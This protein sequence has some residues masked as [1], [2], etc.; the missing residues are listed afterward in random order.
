RV[1][2]V[3][4]NL[5]RTVTT[6]EKVLASLN[7]SALP[8]IKQRFP[9]VSFAVAG[10]AEES[11]EA[12]GA[13]ASLSLM[14]MLII[15]ALL[16][17]P[18]RSYLQP[19]VIMSVI[20]FGAMGAIIGHYIMGWDL[21]FFSLLGMM[22]LSGVVVNA[23]LVLVDYINRQ[24]RTGTP[25]EEAVLTAGSA[26]FRPIVLTSATTFVGLVPLIS[27][28]SLATKIFVPMAISLSF[29]VLFATAITLFL[30][31]C[32]YLMLDDVLKAQKQ[33]RGGARKKLK[34][35]LGI[36]QS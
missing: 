31:P 7:K 14:A 23:S 28:S 32:I 13:M 22:A 36:T 27:T 16:A 30:V 5:D 21:V 12:M 18:L 29:G 24:V 15:Y 6:P 35:A 9:G 25:I 3:Q 17:I 1:I 2:R 20:P 34:T 4:A 10:E 33:W 26:R 8:E 11:M 19:L